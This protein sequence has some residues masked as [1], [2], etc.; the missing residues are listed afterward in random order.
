MGQLWPTV[1]RAL[2]GPLN[3]DCMI[4]PRQSEASLRKHRHRQLRSF[5]NA[6]TYKMIRATGVKEYRSPL[7]HLQGRWSAGSLHWLV[8][9]GY[10]ACGNASGGNALGSWS[11]VSGKSSESF[12]GGLWRSAYDRSPTFRMMS[13]SLPFRC[14]AVTRQHVNHPSI[15]FAS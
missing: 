11:L 9:A 14:C 2:V 10:V 15:E 1:T 12:T 6:E 7:H 13:G 3:C 4:A 5:I 8:S